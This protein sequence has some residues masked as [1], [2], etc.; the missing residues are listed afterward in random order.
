MILDF[1]DSPTKHWT[2]RARR[3]F[4]SPGKAA[5]SVDTGGISGFCQR[6]MTEKRP[7]R[8][9]MFS[10]RINNCAQAAFEP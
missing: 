9:P 2:K 5:G 3:G 4:F 7:T 8:R 1:I 6:S 10:W